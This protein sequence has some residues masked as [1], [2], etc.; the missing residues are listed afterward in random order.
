MINDN[1][2]KLKEEIEQLKNSLPKRIDPAFISH[3]SKIPYKVLD[4]KTALLYRIYDLA[5]DSFELFSN[6]RFLSGTIISRS[7]I[8][9]VT[10]LYYLCSNMNKTIKD[11]DIKYFDEK[12][13]QLILGSRNKITKLES[14]NILTIIKKVNKELKIDGKDDALLFCYELM[15][16]Y[17][18]PNWKGTEG[19]YAKINFEEIYTDFGFNLQDEFKKE[20][21]IQ[22]LPIAT[23]MEITIISIKW[24]NEII[25]DFIQV[26]EEIK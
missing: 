9:T 2:L 4:L 21:S 26:C 16:E 6:N 14:I 1:V 18:H 19:L 10:V 5:N 3:I 8:E 11:K 13:M 7:L 25:N 12:I 15:C 17:A 20:V 23:A 24:F 22:I